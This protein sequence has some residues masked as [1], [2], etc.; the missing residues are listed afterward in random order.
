MKKEVF[1]GSVWQQGDGI[2]PDVIP[3]VLFA[4]CAFC[5]KVIASMTRV[6]TSPWFLLCREVVWWHG[7][8]QVQ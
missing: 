6:D 7:W 3:D 2:A 4:Y 5:V 1:G 8:H